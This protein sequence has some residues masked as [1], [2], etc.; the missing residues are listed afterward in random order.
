MLNTARIRCHKVVERTRAVP[1]VHALARRERERRVVEHE[2]HLGAVERGRARELL[3]EHLR[4]ERHLV[5][6]PELAVAPHRAPRRQ[7]RGVLGEPEPGERHVDRRVVAELEVEGL[8]V[9]GGVRKAVMANQYIGRE[10]T[11]RSGRGEVE[12]AYRS[13]SFFTKR[14]PSTGPMSPGR[15]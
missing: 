13:A 10:H 15:L 11:Q 7:L 14:P 5:R 6:R 2:P 1:P 8:R 3:P 12:R 9:A 4:R